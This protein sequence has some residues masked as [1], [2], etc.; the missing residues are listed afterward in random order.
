[1][2]DVFGKSGV[3][4]PERKKRMLRFQENNEINC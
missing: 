3:K 2:K 4:D 1:M